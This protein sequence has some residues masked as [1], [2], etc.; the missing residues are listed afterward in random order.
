VGRFSKLKKRRVV[1]TSGALFADRIS[2]ITK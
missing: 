1:Y 2:A